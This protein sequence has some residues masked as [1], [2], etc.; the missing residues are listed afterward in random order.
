MQRS[1][2][3]RKSPIRAARGTA[4]KGMLNRGPTKKR[5][6]SGTRSKVQKGPIRDA[7]HLARV[8]TLPCAVCQWPPPNQ[9]HHIRECFPR[10]MG[11]RVGDDKVLP[12]CEGHHRIVHSISKLFWFSMRMKAAPIAAALYAETLSLRGKANTKSSVA[13]LQPRREG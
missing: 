9:A 10:T 7:D 6:D 11:V 3:K 2:I 4:A 1:G 8:R 12:M 13:A 5:R